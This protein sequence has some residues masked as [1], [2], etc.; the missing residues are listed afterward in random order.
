MPTTEPPMPDSESR[1]A[2]VLAL[3]EEFLARYRRGERP[4]MTEY[5]ATS[6]RPWR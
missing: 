4:P 5:T 1:S 3:A 6:S 2:A